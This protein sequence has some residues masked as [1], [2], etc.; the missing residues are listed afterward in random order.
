MLRDFNFAASEMEA[1]HLIALTHKQVRI[2]DIGRYSVPEEEWAER[3]GRIISQGLAQEIMI[4][5]TC[6][7]IEFFFCASPDSCHTTEDIQQFLKVIYPQNS[8]SD[9]GWMAE[10]CVHFEGEKAVLHLLEV[11]SSL[12][13]LVVGERE[14]ITQVRKAYEKC[15]LLGLCGDAIRIAVQHAIVSAK[16]VFTDTGISTRPVSVVSLAYR[17]LAE[18]G[19]PKDARFVFIGAGQ[20]NALMARLLIKH[21]YRNFRVFN[22]SLPRAESLGRELNSP[23]FRLA[24]L[25]REGRG[26]DVIISCTAAAD[27]IIHQD[28]YQEILGGDTRKKLVIDLAVPHDFSPEVISSNNIRFIDVS[29]L[30]QL[31]ESNLQERRTELGACMTIL[32]R[33][34]QEFRSVFKIRQLEIAMGEVPGQVR[35]IRNQALNHVFQ[36]EIQQLDDHSRELIEKVAEYMEKKFIAVPMKLSRKFAGKEA[37]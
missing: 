9:L 32:E 36:K 35:A 33:R 34:M 28:I 31:A 13:S 14:I 30:Q 11:T 7:R 20:T 19:I 37:L 16:E 15:R 18:S 24:D 3:L 21:G 1:Y 25:A 2:E 27:H 8:D 6:N 4:L 29:L 26:F 17:K 23:F 22:R 10:N 5:S 12:H